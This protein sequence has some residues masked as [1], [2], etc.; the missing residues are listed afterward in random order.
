MKRYKAGRLGRL[1]AA[2]A[3]AAMTLGGCGGAQE[4]PVPAPAQDAV[5]TAQ[6]TEEAKPQETQETQSTGVS[7]R[8]TGP[9]KTD[10]VEET[11]KEEEPE[12][13]IYGEEP[14]EKRSRPAV[15][16]R[17]TYE[18]PAEAPEY[19]IYIQPVEYLNQEY[20]LGMDL[21]S[22][23][24]EEASGVTWKNAAGQEQDLFEIFAENGL[25]YVRVRVWNDPFDAEGHGYGGGNCNAETAGIIGRRA[26]EVGMKLNVDFHYS[27]FWADPS[28]QMVPKAWADLNA[29]EKA[30]ALYTYTKESLESILDAG[31]DVGMVQIGNEINPGMS[32]E[33]FDANVIKLLKAG[34]QAVR[35]VAWEYDAD[36]R[37]AVH[38]TNV[39][40]PDG[41]YKKANWLKDQKLDYDIFGVSYYPYWHGPFENMQQVLASVRK[42]TDKEVMILETAVPYTGEEGDGTGN[43]V[44]AEDITG[45][46]QASVQCQAQAVRDVI[47][48]SAEAGA[49]G[50]FYWEG[51][52]T[53]VSDGGYTANFPVWEEY[54]SGWA[55]SYAADYDPKDAGVYYGGSSWDNQAFFDFGG[56]ELPSLGVF[57]YLRTGTV[58]EP[59]VEMVEDPVIETAIGSAPEMPQRVNAIFN[60]RALNRTID[61]EWSASD[62]AAVNTN[63]GGEYKV[64][65]TYDGGKVVA[66]VKVMNVNFLANGSFEEEDASMWQVRYEGSADPT[67]VQTKASDAKT[68]EK[69]YHFWSTSD[70]FFD[71]YQTVTDLAP[72]TYGAAGFFQGGDCGDCDIYLYV[73]VG[74]KDPVTAKV[75]PNGWVQW[76]NPVIEGVEV[77]QGESVTVGF[78]VQAAAQGWGTM[79][80]VELYRMTE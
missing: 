26:A 3:V 71:V 37:I 72:G 56:T 2:A 52:W 21:S 47:A 62:L 23:L 65:G 66:V 33:R 9:E 58:C 64:E 19:D 34:S 61:V 68:G 25:N 75:T 80:D 16:V 30:K 14:A 29:D 32:G 22:V 36:I 40:N 31:A 41:I 6:A 17:Y 20:V 43:S 63:K 35:D 11:A 45:Q 69:A 1:L 73:Q 79:D 70:L 7:G 48:A 27:D 13:R 4:A 12:G 57:R 5:Q 15:D 59:K 39:D 53:P 76:Q 51:A 28:K 38:F 42:I 18:A 54:G 67:D 50:C 55:S 78:H 46:Y 49:V 8:K 60:N 44:S 10:Q 74:D 24:A 77:A